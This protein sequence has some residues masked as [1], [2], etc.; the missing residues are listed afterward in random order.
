MVNSKLVAAV[1]MV[2]LFLITGCAQQQIQQQ[3]VVPEQETSEMTEIPVEEKAP[4]QQEETKNETPQKEESTEE[5]MPEEVFILSSSSYTDRF[6]R[7]VVVGEV[8]NNINE[9]I[10][11]VKIVCDFY[12]DEDNKIGSKF[13]F[14][15]NTAIIPGEKSPFGLTFSDLS[16]SRYECG[17]QYSPTEGRIREVFELLEKT[18]QPDSKGN[19]EVIGTVNNLAG[20]DRDD[21]KIIGTFY[22]DKGNVVDVKTTF[23]ELEDTRSGRTHKFYILIEEKNVAKKIDH[24]TMQLES[25]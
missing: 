11:N 18:G 2:T 19:Y 22:D 23:I 24:F 17:L 13:T 25:T 6:K 20:E 8:L 14:A 3:V 5:E 12:D 1:F 21:L 4:V 15:E 9:M 7:Y 16:V 10:K